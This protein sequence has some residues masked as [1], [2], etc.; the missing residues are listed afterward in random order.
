M[1]AWGRQTPTIRVATLESK[2]Q[3]SDIFGNVEI[4]SIRIYNLQTQENICVAKIF[5]S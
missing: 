2:S 3:I 1:K 4:H 5:L